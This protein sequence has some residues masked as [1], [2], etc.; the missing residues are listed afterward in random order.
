MIRR[1]F[2]AAGAAFAISFPASA[3]TVAPSADQIERSLSASPRVVLPRNKRVNR[4]QLL[5]RH[6][7]RRHAPSIDIQAINFAFGSAQIPHSERYKVERIARAMRRV[8]RRDPGEVFL[9]EG[10]TDAVGSRSS[11][12]RLSRRR[13]GSLKRDL[14]R[15]F[16]IPP[17]ALETAGYGEDFLLIPTPY[18]EWRNRRVTLRRVT[19]FLL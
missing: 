3:Q 13:A 4:Q 2:L 6:D 15:I 5:R 9:I 7:L 14:V 8:L 1:Q 19:D 17:Y 16:G 10:H 11:N 18:E 12:Y